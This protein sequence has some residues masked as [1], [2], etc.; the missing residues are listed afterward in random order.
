MTSS[1][2]ALSWEGLLKRENLQ[3]HQQRMG[4]N[5][6]AAPWSHCF[7][8]LPSHSSYPSGPTMDPVG[9]LEQSWDSFLSSSSLMLNQC[10]YKKT[11]EYIYIYISHSLRRVLPAFVTLGLVPMT[12]PSCF[13]WSNQDKKQQQDRR[14]LVKK[15]GQRC[16]SRAKVMGY[17]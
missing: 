8:M 3:R 12:L 13:Q 14:A 10:K 6:E 1:S 16:L 11:N 2:G 15:I 17:C 7:H 4:L 9:T 5:L